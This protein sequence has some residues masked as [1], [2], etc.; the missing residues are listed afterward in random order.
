MQEWHEGPAH[1]QAERTTIVSTAYGEPHEYQRTLAGATVLQIVPT[2]HND[3]V[4]RTAIAVAQMLLHSGA[5]A[6]VASDEGPL[7][8]ELRARGGEWVLL[9]NDT[10]NLFR[11]R[12]NAR[13]LEQLCVG[14]RIDIIHAQSAG[15]AWSALAAI[16]RS[17]VWLVTTLPDVPPTDSRLR[18]F[19][20]SGLTR[21]DRIV[22]TSAYAA[23]PMVERYRIPRERVRIAPRCIDTAQFDPSAVAQER[24]AAVRRSWSVA[25][26]ERIVLLPGRVAR[27]NGHMT[28][29]DAVEILADHGLRGVSFVLA[30]D[31]SSNRRYARSVRK[32]AQA[33]YVDSIIR[34]TGPCRDMPAAYAAAEIIVLPALEPPATGRIAAE[35]QAMARP[36]IASSIGPLPEN[37]LVPPR[38]AEQLR[39]GW[40]VAPGEP[41]EL[42]RALTAALALDDF[43]YQSLA[44]RARQ[45]AEHMFSPQSVAANLC[46][47]Y[48]SILVRTA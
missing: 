10:S 31:D 15:A 13:Q 42:A 27:W 12:G 41:A 48:T 40:L 21:G 18:A 35:A 2:L 4:G 29:V 32:R 33:R 37:V 38:M 16:A 44:A 5:R 6:I 34:M 17:P 43:A 25:E 39:T 46:E 14:E 23:A 9:R 47:V 28:L 1:K 36:V 11:L 20:H 8:A 3:P 30:G 22:A 24:I 45:F 26:G 19:F 7:V